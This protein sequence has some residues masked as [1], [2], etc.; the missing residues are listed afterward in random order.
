M[1]IRIYADFNNCEE[2]GKVRLNTNGSLGDLFRVK[3]QIHAGMPVWLYDEEFEVESKLE[4]DKKWKIWMGDP[5]W[6]TIRYFDE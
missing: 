6:S 4:Y 2:N 1:V 3:K 5:H